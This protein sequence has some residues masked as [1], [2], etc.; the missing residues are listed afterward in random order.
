MA[1]VERI[2]S[3]KSINQVGANVAVG[4][5]IE[6]F[7]GTTVGVKVGVEVAVIVGVMV[8]KRPG[9]LLHPN[10]KKALITPYTRT[11]FQTIFEIL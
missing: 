10:K 5:G 8:A 7:V 6:V 2:G 3:A 4:V 1:I 11:I 9:R